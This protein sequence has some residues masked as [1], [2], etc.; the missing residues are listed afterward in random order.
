[1]AL[2]GLVLGTLAGVLLSAL[3][4]QRG[5]DPGTLTA[6]GTWTPCVLR[7][8]LAAAL[9]LAVAP[10]RRDAGRA[11]SPTA[12]L[13]GAALGFAVHATW[14]EPWLMPLGL[15]PQGWTG[16]LGTLAAG[17]LALVVLGGERRAPAGDEPAAGAA[18]LAGIALAAG[19]ATVAL[20]SLERPLALL[21]SGLR[22]DGAVFGA[23]AL[24][25]AAL[26]AGAFG[27]PLRR[28][29]GPR[30]ALPGGLAL[31]AAAAA[32]GL[33]ALQPL[34]DRAGLDTY[35]RKYGLDPSN[36][37]M[38]GYDALLGGRALVAP[39]LLLGAALAT[40]RRRGALSATLAGT[41]LGLL[42]V[43]LGLDAA[44]GTLEI[45]GT[46]GLAAERLL[47]AGALVA[48]LGAIL[49]LVGGPAARGPRLAGIALA[50]GA[51]LCALWFGPRA[52]VPLSPWE[53]FRPQP[54]WM[55]ESAVGLLTIERRADGPAVTV[56]RARVTP[57]DAERDAELFALSMELVPER[58]RRGARVLLVGQ[59]TAWRALELANLGVASVDRTA[60]WHA[61]LPEIEARELE[62][63]RRPSGAILSPSEARRRIAA[64]EYDLIVAPPTE[65]AAPVAPA[66]DVPSG[67][68]AVRWLRSRDWLAD[69][70]LGDGVL[71]AADPFGD[72]IVAVVDG[73]DGHAALWPAGEPVA[74]PDAW[75]WLGTR[76][77]ERE[78]AA[79]EA[80]A[81]RLARAAAGTP[82]ERFARGLAAHYAAQRRSSPWD[83][84]EQA[85]EL[86]DE[87]L[88][89]LSA[90]AL[91]LRDHPTVRSFWNRAAGVLVGKRAIDEIE[92]HVAPLAQAELD[93]GRPWPELERAR[94]RADLELLDPAMA[95]WRLLRLIEL[96][97]T[98]LDLR[99]TCADAM[100]RAGDAEGAVEQVRVVLEVQPDR[101]DAERLLAIALARAGDPAAAERIEAL[102]R[103]DPG[104]DALR[105]Y[106]LPGPL[107]P[108]EPEFDPGPGLDAHDGTDG[109][110]AEDFGHE[111]HGHGQ[112][113]SP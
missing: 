82:L 61:S 77:L 59:L 69:R 25:L 58:A 96:E 14:L 6:L 13:V 80:L 108:Y 94:V 36:L 103:E 50:A 3:R 84:A 68:V 107:P 98:S 56:D 90:G 87:A 92:R 104:D 22:D 31:A 8:A 7:A 45:E 10:R 44:G 76:L 54:S 110:D 89:D 105:A 109:L 4:P 70:D 60:P 78:Q 55:H 85:V 2:N 30:A 65:G 12:L 33:A 28:A 49:A 24:A 53:R 91:G 101:H 40:L 97:P 46:R 113:D 100:L 86:D 9:A 27:A 67:A 39:C 35:L 34:S 62:G 57:A 5:V 29:L 48:G 81:G 51:G 11:P 47:P 74:R 1:M 18:E 66:L 88:A 23:V 93:A 99:M 106:L 21:S 37:G 20:A 15:A 41:A 43:P 38:L 42:A 26:G 95:A 83:T 32:V 79:A 71:V 73:A 63:H 19:G 111:G 102:L 16:L 112:P 52:S 17:G 64:G 72:L 75:R